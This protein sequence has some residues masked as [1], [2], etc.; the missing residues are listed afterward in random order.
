MTHPMKD[1]IVVLPGI[2]GSVLR[3][4]NKDVWAPSSGAVWNFLKTRSTS[5]RSLALDG[6][7]DGSLADLD[8][9]VVA[10]RLM[11]DVHL[12]PGLFTIDGYSGIRDNLL[13]TFDITEGKNYFEFPYDWRRHND[14]HGRRLRSQTTTWL[15]QWR[16]E[17]GNDD[18]KLI[19]LAHSMGG[20]VARS[21]LEVHDGWKDTSRLITFG[22]PYSG[23]LNSLDFIANGFKKGIGPIGLDLSELVRSL[24][25]I[26]QLLPAV[27]CIDVAG[28]N[29][30]IEDIAVP[31][32]APSL[33]TAAL[34]FHRQLGEA[35]AAGPGG[36]IHPIVGIEQRTLQAASFDGSNIVVTKDLDLQ[37]I[38]QFGD[39]TVPRWSATPPEMD[40]LATAVYV[41]GQHG[42]LQNTKTS[43]THVA[44]LLTETPQR[45]FQQAGAIDFIGIDLDD[46]YLVG[47]DIEIEL[48]SGAIGASFEVSIADLA[49]GADAIPAFTVDNLDGDD[50]VR[51]TTGGLAEGTYQ[52]TVT[53]PGADALPVSRPIL[54]GVD[55]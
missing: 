40:D 22:T 15:N 45:P 39:G 28:E 10:S 36:R 1:I 33:A 41:A 16:T 43:L 31:H 38:A 53:T 9:G 30:G 21:F 25:S 11:P 48:R 24:T 3:K 47:E 50:V 42:G 32:L 23:S 17:S 35:A 13:A 29:K 19:L 46:F 26:Q 49:T 7:D 6:H 2:M 18:A 37:G 20:L 54:V 44:G 55:Q 51:A 27:K 5:V 8:D 52:V 4:D 14:A 12:I 34:D